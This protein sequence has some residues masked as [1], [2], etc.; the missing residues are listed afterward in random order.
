[1]Y[2]KL[3]SYSHFIWRTPS[4]FD[5]VGLFLS[6]DSCSFFSAFLVRCF[7]TS[8]CGGA[9]ARHFSSCCNERPFDFAFDKTEKWMLLR[10]DCLFKG[11]LEFV[12]RF[13][14]WCSPPISFSQSPI[15]LCILFCRS[16][17]LCPQSFL[18]GKESFFFHSVDFVFLFHVIFRMRTQKKKQYLI[19]YLVVTNNGKVVWWQGNVATRTMVAWWRRGYARPWWK[20]TIQWRAKKKSL[21]TIFG[22]YSQNE[23]Q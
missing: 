10:N 22:I 6:F 23:C 7:S 18:I 13:F 5:F 8:I 15:P 19:E 16:L 11:T 12:R 4:L 1:M 3:F 21:Q 14:P 17:F 20:C 9:G 2:G